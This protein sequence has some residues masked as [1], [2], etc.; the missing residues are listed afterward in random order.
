MI[1]GVPGGRN[2]P[3]DPFIMTVTDLFVVGNTATVTGVV[4]ASPKG[5]GNGVFV[6]FVFTDNSA[7]DE[8]DEVDGVPIDAGN[9]T[10]ID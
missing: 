3:S 10:V 7:I 8:P 1:N 9:F 4:I 2:N 5:V 6:T